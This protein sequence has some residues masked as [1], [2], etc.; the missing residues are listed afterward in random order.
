MRNVPSNVY[1]IKNAKEPQS[2]MA[3][4]MALS[5]YEKKTQEKRAVASYSE[6]EETGHCYVL[7]KSIAQ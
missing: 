1:Y 2:P 3:E 4:I 7:F 5:R 6:V